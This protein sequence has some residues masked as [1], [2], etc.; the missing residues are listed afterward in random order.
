MEKLR[1]KLK[2]FQYLLYP[3]DYLLVEFNGKIYDGSDQ[4]VLQIIDD[5]IDIHYM[6]ESIL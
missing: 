2:S 1:N 4:K 3:L 5:W 6:K